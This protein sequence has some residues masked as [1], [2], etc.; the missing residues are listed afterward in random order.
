MEGREMN[1]V[2]AIRIRGKATHADD[3]VAWFAQEEN[4]EIR[5]F[6]RKSP[7]E[8]YRDGGILWNRLIIFDWI[9]YGEEK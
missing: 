5:L 9:P 7:R 2:E 6:Q 4:N 3:D 1:L 8:Y